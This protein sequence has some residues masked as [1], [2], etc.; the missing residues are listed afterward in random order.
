M[1]YSTNSQMSDTQ[2]DAISLIAKGH[3]VFVTGNAGTGKSFVLS[4]IKQIFRMENSE[5]AITASTGIAA[6]NLSARTIHSWAAVG[7]GEHPAQYYVD[8]ILTSKKLSEVRK[9]IKKCKILAIDEVSMISAD[10][11]NK[12]DRIFKAVRRSTEPFGGIQMVLFGDFFQLPPIS[13]P[14]SETY[15]AFESS[16]WQ[17]ANFKTIVLTKIFRQSDLRYIEVL[18]N[19]RYGRIKKED[20]DILKSRVLKPPSDLKVTNISTHNYMVE[21]S[22]TNCLNAI[23]D[24]AY[25]YNMSF[26]GEQNHI[27]FLKRN[28][29]SPET[30]TLKLGARVMMLKNTYNADGIVNGSVGDVTDFIYDEEMRLDL[31]MVKFNN[32]KSKIIYP[33]EWRLEEFNYEKMEPITLAGVVQVPLMLAWSIT[34]HKSQGMTLDYINCEIDKAFEAGQVYVGLS[35]VKSL[36][37]LFLERMPQKFFSA[38]NKVLEFENNNYCW[39]KRILE[40]EDA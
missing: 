22:N 30:L 39:S 27:D 11:M 9:R 18:N 6:V 24:K 14:G 7:T 15:F 10:L 33:E 28:C 19:I 32:G 2:H 16:A 20:I 23:K 38:N 40:L 26:M 5:F 12:L 36:E 17:E 25:S 21:K 37:G 35:R 34:V 4:A 3:N 1:K 8:Y 31:P 29:L 13:K